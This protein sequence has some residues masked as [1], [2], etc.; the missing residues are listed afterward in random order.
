VDSG[1]A[2]EKVQS[3]ED[4]FRKTFLDRVILGTLLVTFGRS[5][6]QLSFWRLWVFTA[7]SWRL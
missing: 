5:D 1:Q 2:I 4:L 3:L 6:S 7:T